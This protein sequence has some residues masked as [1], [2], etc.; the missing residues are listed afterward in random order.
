MVKS[1]LR[2]ELTR[3]GGLINSPASN[4]CW[5]PTANVVATPTL[6]NITI[7]DL[8]KVS[9]PTHG[10]RGAVGEQPGE[11]SVDQLSEWRSMAQ[12]SSDRLCRQHQSDLMCVCVCV[13]ISTPASDGVN[14]YS[15]S[16]IDHLCTTCALTAHR[17]ASLCVA[18]DVSSQLLITCCAPPRRAHRCTE[19]QLCH[20]RGGCL[21]VSSS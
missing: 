9:H 16:T 8:K 2:Y 4:V 14:Q 12:F 10:N 19:Q 5:D 21:A 7:W 3:T 13:T 17:R 15:E 20:H 18:H 11:Q 6:E 1:Y